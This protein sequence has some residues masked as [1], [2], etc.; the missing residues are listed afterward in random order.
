MHMITLFDEKK[1]K[2]IEKNELNIRIGLFLN[3]FVL[4]ILRMLEF[5]ISIYVFVGILL[6]SSCSLLPQV[7]TRL[8]LKDLT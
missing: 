6:N 5:G 2:K 4:L 8:V 7:C 3:L 1:I